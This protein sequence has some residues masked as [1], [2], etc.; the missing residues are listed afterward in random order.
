MENH[1]KINERDLKKIKEVTKYTIETSIMMISNRVV[2]D[3]MLY[4]QDNN[5]LEIGRFNR[6]EKIYDERLSEELFNDIKNR[7]E[8]NIEKETE[9]IKEKIMKDFFNELK[10]LT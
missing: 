6:I 4:C 5:L 7:L 9:A 2:N 3:F 8:K 10:F 1:F